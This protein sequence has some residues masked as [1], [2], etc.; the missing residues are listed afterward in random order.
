MSKKKILIIVLVAVIIVLALISLL[1]KKTDDKQ[2]SGKERITTEESIELSIGGQVEETTI[3]LI[4]RLFS[5]IA[6]SGSD[7]TGNSINIETINENR[8]KTEKFTEFPTKIINNAGG[9]INTSSNNPEP[10]VSQNPVVEYEPTTKKKSDSKKQT[11]KATQKTTQKP[12]ETTPKANNNV[13]AQSEDYSAIGKSNTNYIR[14]IIKNNIVGTENNNL[15]NLAIYMAKNN[16]TDSS[17]A[18]EN[19][20]GYN[21][22]KTK[23]KYVTKTFTSTEAE[24][25]D[26]VAVSVSSY[27]AGSY[28]KYGMGI[29][30]YLDGGKYKVYVVLVYQI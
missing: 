18:A 6:E 15:K 26:E 17:S 22:L 1:G 12:K 21:T 16:K 2:S 23:C 27:L 29:H 30:T 24:I 28:S 7:E 14:Q 20:C 25:I 19:L 4:T 8:K 11:Q 3:E 9:K 13:P 10:E 5:D